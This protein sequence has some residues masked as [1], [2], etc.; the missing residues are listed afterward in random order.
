MG[1]YAGLIINGQNSDRGSSGYSV[2][3]I[4]DINGDGIADIAISAPEASVYDAQN[5]R[6][7]FDRGQV[8][9]VFGQTTGDFD[10]SIDLS[11]LDGTDGFAITPQLDLTDNN[12]G[13]S[14]YQADGSRF[15]N[16]VKGLGDVNGDGVDDFGIVQR[17]TD[18]AGGYYY[19]GGNRG[20][21]GI[22]GVAY[23]IYG[24]QEPWNAVENIEEVAGFRIDAE[25]YVSSIVALGDVNGDGIVDIGLNTVNRYTGQTASVGYTRL[26]DYDGN[27]VYDPYTQDT[28]YQGSSDIQIGEAK[29]FVIYGTDEE[30]ISQD[31]IADPTNQGGGFYGPQVFTAVST[32]P[33]TSEVIVNTE[34]LDGSDGFTII[35][36]RT[37]TGGAYYGNYN[38]Y[39]GSQFPVGIESM[40]DFN[41]DGFADIMVENTDYYAPDIYIISGPDIYDR[42]GGEIYSSTSG[43][44]IVFGQDG[45]PSVN[46]IDV[47]NFVVPEG[48]DFRVSSFATFDES[49]ANLGDVSGDDKS[50]IGF[51]GFISTD[52]NPVDGVT[53]NINTV[54]V[55]NGTEDDPFSDAAGGNSTPEARSFVAQDVVDGQGAIY[56]DAQSV[57]G[58]SNT[59]GL[60]NSIV[61]GVGDVNGDGVDDFVIA[62][63]RST[64]SGEIDAPTDFS[65]VMY[66]VFGQDSAV[67]GLFDLN[68]LVDDG[69]AYRFLPPTGEIFFTLNWG[70]VAA[71]GDLN[72]G[73]L[74]DILVGIQ[75][76]RFSE[77][78][79]PTTYVI[80]GEGLEAADAVDGTVDNSINLVNLNVDLDT[81]L[82]PTEIGFSP[83]GSSNRFLQEGDSG[84]TIFAFTVLRSG[85]VTETV[86]FDYEVL[87]NGFSPAT[88]DDFVG[89]V[90]PTGTVTFADGEEAAV[91]EIEVQGDVTIENDEFFSLNITGAQTSSVLDVQI[92]DA[93]A[94]GTIDNDDFPAFIRMNSPVTTE[95]G[96]LVF[97]VTRS[98]D[99]SSEVTV[100][101][102]VVANSFAPVSASDIADVNGL[103][104]GLGQTGTLTFGP[105]EISQTITVT[106]VDDALIEN[107][108]IVRINLTNPIADSGEVTLLSSSG[109]GRINDNDFA[110]EIFAQGGRSYFEG[111][112]P[113]GQTEVILEIVRRGD[114]DG[115]TDVTY[116]LNPLPSPGDFFAADGNDIDS[117]LPSFGNVVR[118]EDGETVKE[119]VININ[120]DGII[121][122]RES[123]ELRITEVET[124]NNA[125]YTV[126]RPNATVT[127]LNDD[128][129]PAVPPPG[130]EADVFGDPHI[131]TLDGLGYDFQAVGEYVLVESTIVDDTRDFQVQVRFEPLPGS[132]LVSVT[133]RMAVNIGDDIV[134]ID[135]LGDDPLLINGVP[136]TA[137]QLALGSLDASGGDFPNVFYDADL[138]AFTIVL[139]DLDEQLQIKNMDGVL[140]ICVFLSNEAGGHANNVIGLMGNAN[141]DTTDDLMTRDGSTTYTDP[142][143]DE[144]YVDY[145]D[146]W[147]ITS[148]EREF[149][150]AEDAGNFPTGFPAAKITVADLPDT[151]L[152]AAE[153]AV[154][155]AGITDPIIRESAILDFALTGD[156]N[157]VQGALGLAADPI[158]EIEVTDAPEMPLSIGVTPAETS[159]T[160]GDT[161]SQ[162][163]SFAFYRIGDDSQDIVVDYA[164]G[165]DIDAADLATGTALTGQVTILA[166]EETA[167][168][169]IDVNGDLAT[170]NDED[171]VVSITGNDA[172]ALIASAN[173][174]TAVETD[175]FAP[176]AEDDSFSVGENS[177]LSGDLFAA[178][179]SDA[180]SDPEGDTL[181]VTA[182]NGAAVSDGDSIVLASG[183][184]LVINA[185]GTFTYDPSGASDAEDA[186]DDLGDGGAAIDRFTYT[187]SDGNGGESTAT[188]TINIDGENDAPVAVDDEGSADEGSSVVVDVLA[189]DTDVDSDSIEISAAVG[190]TEP[191]FGSVVQDDDGNLV[192]T[193]DDPNFS[194]TDRFSYI[195][196]DGSATAE[197][198][199]DV[200]VNAVDDAPVAGDD[201]LDTDEDTIQSINLFDN[202]SSVVPDA[203]L[204]VTSVRD[205]AGAE[206]ALGVETELPEGGLLL[207]ETDGTATFNPAG[208]YEA[209]GFNPQPEPPAQTIALIYTVSDG[210]E[211]TE[212]AFDIN[213]RGVNDAPIAAEPGEPVE[214]SEDD[215]P[216]GLDLLA[217]ATDVDSDELTLTNATA[218]WS[219]GNLSLTF[220]ASGEA[221]FNP[222][223]LGSMLDAGDS[224]LVTIDYTISDGNDT[225]DSSAEVLVL[226]ADDEP[227][228]LNLIVGTDDKDVLNGTEGADE[229]RGL[230]GGDRIDGGDGEDVINAGSG[231]DWNVRGGNDADIFEF[232]I[233]DERVRILDFEDGLDL[234]RFTDGLT[235]DDLHISTS[236]SGESVNIFAD[237]TA[238]RLIIRVEE[239][240]VIDQN[241][242]LFSGEPPM[243][244]GEEI[245]GTP[246]R[247]LLFGT[248]GDDTIR[249]GDGSD[250]IDGGAGD[251]LIEAGAGKDWSVRGGQGADIF[252]FGSGDDRV[253]ILD[254][255]DGIDMLQITGG[256]SFE[257][258]SINL[259][260]N[261]FVGEDRLIVKSD[262]EITL[263]EAD[264]IFT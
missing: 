30:R 136:I 39:G 252:E 250:K 27:G 129:R 227:S 214:V 80:F 206:I 117:F 85:N 231:K 11:D 223:Q 201:A 232:G 28:L 54:V 105:G 207:V 25:G 161:G 57:S 116:D 125:D 150:D 49:R 42:T 208:D 111:S 70:D 118:F 86:S 163:L 174:T 6:T 225:A 221:T 219:G 9:I 19:E 211:E 247:D 123:F 143:F 45:G 10:T 51:R 263:T 40:G 113:S 210:Q 249:A 202:D 177:V 34:L 200:T 2:D 181:S 109:L 35:T 141:G 84:T 162:T 178:N 53:E 91:V 89:G 22:N 173:G 93:T 238:D 259:N 255:E 31:P 197:A 187:I 119:V 185:D 217:G 98:G 12:Y 203:T 171:L 92:N 168:L 59:I 230:D 244:P 140:N 101:F 4:G 195:I 147:K 72:D 64:T 167:T 237:S 65:S 262:D 82:R 215:A 205:S 165:G 228:D 106:P 242:F 142:T 164:I 236:S 115:V 188:A 148:A 69:Q 212:A 63:I 7:A 43:N 81:G 241:D 254:F 1:N 67:S 160:E 107:Q 189:N 38:F 29:S 224:A 204:T 184:I 131:V 256:L 121:E 132:D 56:Y 41:G 122:P 170:E 14:L 156:D 159:V 75:G 145:A 33:N 139:N 124:F 213:I 135:A 166:G 260:N 71:A 239:G 220:D 76:N 180:D 192:Y 96:Q 134:E 79:E 17:A 46:E 102:S 144:L 95:D 94:F 137:E 175:D 196:T 83:F 87:G 21:S 36:G 234:I 151:V 226:G 153:A 37:G 245:I 24:G 110:P 176:T 128:G 138:S 8:Y 104:G 191:E 158:E 18:S 190:S 90:L 253:R 114:T 61:R 146:S 251:D 149:T 60:T 26:Y 209:Q 199:V 264:F 182:I 179:P 229:I 88:G 47:S 193:P 130:V 216:I 16:D 183:A 112:E 74:D 23:V 261:V 194:G 240:D 103:G 13:S 152:A 133:T 233:G 44:F 5:E 97:D 20:Y 126:T 127:I 222:G 62:G 52:N 235:A 218:S 68:T 257:D 172:G 243:D 78:E 186:F 246:D 77:V 248:T 32:D 55:L 58:F 48:A 120:H 99:T 157:F 15:G 100:D 3:G 198:F 258:L 169:S 155:A 66:L 108:E 50:E 154:D 73:G